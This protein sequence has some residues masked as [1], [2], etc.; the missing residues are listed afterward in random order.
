M[1]PEQMRGE[2]LDV[3]S[4]IYSFG[5]LWFRIFTGNV[6]YPGRSFEEIRLAS[7]DLT[8]PSMGEALEHYQPIVD[9]TLAG[10]RDLRFSTAQELI[11]S[12]DHQFGSATGVHR[13]PYFE[14]RRNN[15]RHDDATGMHHQER[16]RSGQERIQDHA[17]P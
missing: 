2:S 10:N 13:L 1:S 11:D 14:E 3:R 9:K 5:A 8:A 16:R 6:P 17:M 12:I 15:G 4:D 7:D